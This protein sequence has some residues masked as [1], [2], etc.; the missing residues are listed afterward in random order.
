[1]GVKPLAD[2]A[3][4]YL[5]LADSIRSEGE[6]S[7]K[8]E[9]TRMR[10]PLYPMFLAVIQ[11]ILG[12]NIRFVQVI[13]ALLITGTV[14]IFYSLARRIF[15]ARISF[16]AAVLLSIYIPFTVRAAL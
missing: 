15:D 10:Q 6:Y 4:E 11:S 14:V 2:D 3:G 8:G 5:A 7:R 1:M 9:G 13:Q 12:T 16:L